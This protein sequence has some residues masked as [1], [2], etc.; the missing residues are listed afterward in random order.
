VLKPSDFTR[1]VSLPVTTPSVLF[2]LILFFVF[3]EIA[4]LGRLFGF[5]IALVLALQLIVF[6]LPALMRTLMQILE[7]RSKGKEPDPPVVEFLSWIGHA[8]S[9]FPLVHVAVFGY[10]FYLAVGL[11]DAAVAYG[12]A[13]VYALFLPA[14]LVV[15]A[16]THSVLESLR[17]AAIIGL[18]RRCGFSYLTG[19]LFLL[20]AVGM[21]IWLAGQFDS[22]LLTEFAIFYLMFASVAVFGGMVRTLQLEHELEIPDPVNFNEEIFAECQEAFRVSTLNHAYGLVSRGNRA[23]GLEHLYEELADDPDSANGWAWFFGRMMDWENTDAALFFAQQY[24]HHLLHDGEQVAAVKIML[25]CR[26]ANEA[27][28]PLADDLSLA[29]EAAEQCDNDELASLLRQ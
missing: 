26:L 3:F 18:V 19:P 2:S 14:S 12:I 15:L 22:R 25:R 8:W 13:I 29:I 23:G 7:A 10:A 21:I 1:E 11:D 24:L 20:A 6:V 16:V 17:P 28:K 27:F 9:L 5:V 4:L